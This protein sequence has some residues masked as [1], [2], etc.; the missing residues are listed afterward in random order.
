[1]TMG[2]PP[3]LPPPSPDELDAFDATVSPVYVAE[4]TFLSAASMLLLH[5]VKRMKDIQHKSVFEAKSSVW[6]RSL[7]I[8]QKIQ[9][10]C[11][12][13]L[14]GRY[15]KFL[16]NLN[17]HLNPNSAE[18]FHRGWGEGSKTEQKLTQMLARLPD[19]G[20]N[21]GSLAWAKRPPPTACQN[22]QLRVRTCSVLHSIYVFRCGLRHHKNHQHCLLDF[23]RFSRVMPITYLWSLITSDLYWPTSTLIQFRTSC[24]KHAGW[25]IQVASD[26]GP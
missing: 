12:F 24:Y 16:T 7:P 9:S 18:V 14:G 2:T 19:Q 3:P 22:S 25:P 15:S 10:Q 23:V 20:L 11:W 6:K 13:V 17:S 1:M 4:G 21:S 26:Q 5:S 8:F